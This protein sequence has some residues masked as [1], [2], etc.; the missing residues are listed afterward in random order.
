[1]INVRACRH[2]SV[3]VVLDVGVSA[4]LHVTTEKNSDVRQKKGKIR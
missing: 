4:R 2:L 1:M 3:S